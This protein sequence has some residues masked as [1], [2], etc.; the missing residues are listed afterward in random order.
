MPAQ[1]RINTGVRV[2]FV[3]RADKFR[4]PWFHTPTAVVF[5]NDGRGLSRRSPWFFTPITKVFHSKRPSGSP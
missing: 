3:A 4:C 1:R 2:N 5:Y